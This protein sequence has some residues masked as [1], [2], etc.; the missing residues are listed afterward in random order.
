MYG[1]LGS[2][3]IWSTV[4]ISTRERPGEHHYDAIGD[5]GHETQ[6]VSDPDRSRSALSDAKPR[7]RRPVE[8]ES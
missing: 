5:L 1:C 6:V 2:L 7:A 3:K 8:P 4:P